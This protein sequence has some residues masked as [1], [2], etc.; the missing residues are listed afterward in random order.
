[1]IQFDRSSVRFLMKLGFNPRYLGY[2]VTS[3]NNH[4]S[5]MNSNIISSLKVRFLSVF[6][7]WNSSQTTRT[8]ATSRF[9]TQNPIQWRKW[10]GQSL[11][12]LCI[13]IILPL[14]CDQFGVDRDLNSK[15]RM[16]MMNDLLSIFCWSDMV[17]SQI[18]T[19]TGRRNTVNTIYMYMQVWWPLSNI[20]I[21][22]TWSIH[23]AQFEMSIH[24]NPIQYKPRNTIIPITNTA[25]LSFSLH[26][27]ISTHSFHSNQHRQGTSID[28]IETSHVHISMRVSYICR[29]TL[30]MH[31]IKIIWNIQRFETKRCHCDLCVDIEGIKL[32]ESLTLV[33]RK[34]EYRCFGD[35]CDRISRFILN[36]IGMDRHLELCPVDRSG[37]TD[38]YIG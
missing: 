26:R 31:M 24:A 19:V 2:S 13:I 8:A 1:M 33:W 37:L 6:R 9:R 27:S 25:V 10:C 23:R 28:T 12:I 11:T 14:I 38:F 3:R 17:S 4:I 18:T 15:K 36:R 34:G 7:T 35:W 20:E 30:Q 5:S 16:K 21:G 32:P 22:Q 29:S